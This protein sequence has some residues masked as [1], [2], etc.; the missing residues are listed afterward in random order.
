MKIMVI[1]PETGYRKEWMEARERYYKPLCAQ[2]TEVTVL[3]LEGEPAPAEIRSGFTVV[4]VL[5]RVEQAMKEGYDGIFVHCGHDGTVV[6]AK[7]LANI[8]VIGGGE[9]ALHV[10]CMLA[11]RF[12][13]I[14]GLEEFIPNV[15]RQTRL[16][17]VADRIVSIKSIDMPYSEWIERKDKLEERFVDIAKE[18]VEHGAQLILPVELLILTALGPGSTKRLSQKV[19]VTVLDT[20]A[21]AFK[22]IE[23]LANLKLSPSK[24]TFP[25]YPYPAIG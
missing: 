14:T 10:A 17:G 1:V 13:L 21:I 6:D 8:P 19:G 3:S 24:S 9:P 25:S 18:Q 5:K 11:D 23:M 20:N 12:G 2:G 22:V 4:G 7:T 15:A 16:Y